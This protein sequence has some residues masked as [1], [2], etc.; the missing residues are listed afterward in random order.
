M[1][2]AVVVLLAV[3]LF[4]AVGLL[5]EALLA[6]V[7]VSQ[8]VRIEPRTKTIREEMRELRIA[9]NHRLSMSMASNNFP[10]SVEV[11][12]SVLT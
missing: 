8:A 12:A 4:A 1:F 10:V 5:K 2:S 6:V 7:V 3:A 11:A 9:Q